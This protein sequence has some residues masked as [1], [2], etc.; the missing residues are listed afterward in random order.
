MVGIL[1]TKEIYGYGAMLA[2]LKIGATYTNLDV[3]NPINRIEKIVN[4]CNPKILLTDNELDIN[5]KIQD[6]ILNSKNIIN[7]KKK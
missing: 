6:K 5:S 2:C 4:T 3:D 7:F 1:N